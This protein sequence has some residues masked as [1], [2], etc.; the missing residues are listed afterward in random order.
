MGETSRMVGKVARGARQT[1]WGSFA[2]PCVWPNTRQ[3]HLRISPQ[4]LSIYMDMPFDTPEA[5]QST[6]M[7]IP[8][9]SYLVVHWH[10]QN[11]CPT[12]TV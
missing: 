1:A 2:R 3:A 7:S 8:R 11:Q 9:Y 5:W 6:M 12:I 10:P 4:H